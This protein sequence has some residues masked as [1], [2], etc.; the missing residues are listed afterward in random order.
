MRSPRVTPARGWCMRPGHRRGLSLVRHALRVVL[1]HA[2]LV[3][4]AL[5]PALAAA[6]HTLNP[7][8]VEFTASADHAGILADGQ[9]AVTRYQLE[10]YIKDAPAPL[11]TVDLGKPTPDTVN[12]V[13][14]IPTVLIGLPVGQTYVARVT[15]IGPGGEGRSEP[16][17]DFSRSDAPRAPT[18]LRTGGV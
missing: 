7:T 5:W 17:N 11:T 9:P 12:R 13:S 1:V 14:V 4:L 3:L 15:A 10:I 18:N 6:Q 2:S 8:S 16:S